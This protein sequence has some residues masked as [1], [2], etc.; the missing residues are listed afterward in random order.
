MDS[1]WLTLL[2]EA[3]PSAEGKLAEVVACLRQ[4]I[5]QLQQ[6]EREEPEPPIDGATLQ[7]WFLDLCVEHDPA[8]GRRVERSHRRRQDLADS[9]NCVVAK[10]IQAGLLPAGFRVYN[11]PR[12]KRPVLPDVEALLDYPASAFFRL[13]R[14]FVEQVLSHGR[15]GCHEEAAWDVYFGAVFALIALGG[16]CW[17]GAFT[18]IVQ[19]RA[20]HLAH[21][22]QGVLILPQQRGN[23][24]TTVVVQRNSDGQRRKGR[25][26]VRVGVGD[27]AVTVDTPSWVRVHLAPFVATCVAAAA[28]YRARPATPSRRR[29]VR[30]LH[31]GAD[32]LPDRRGESG[33]RPHH[34]PV[35]RMRR[36]FNRWLEQLCRRAGQPVLTVQKLGRLARTHLWLSGVYPEPV[37]A[38]LLGRI[39]YNPVPLNRL[40]IFDGYRRLLNAP[41]WPEQMADR[42]APLSRAS[43]PDVRHDSA[44]LSAA[45]R[46]YAP[47]IEA[48][49]NAVRAFVRGGGTREAAVAGLHS[50]AAGQLGQLGVQASPNRDGLIAG[51]R[52]AYNA[53]IASLL[54]I[55]ERDER[56]LAQI[57]PFNLAAVAL[58]LA[59]WL[60]KPRSDPLTV[61][62]HR[63]DLATVLRLFPRAALT[64][65]DSAALEVLLALDHAA[66]TKQRIR[67]SLRQL[68]RFL[69]K[70]LGVSLPPLEVERWP[71]AGITCAV[72][73]PAIEE[74]EELLA[75]FAR[76]GS[77]EDRNAYLAVCLAFG[78]GLRASE[79]A[80]LRIQD[81]VMAGGAFV[82][83][84]Q[85][86]FDKSR[87]VSL[88]GVSPTLLE[89]LDRIRR[90]R[91]HESGKDPLA[92][93]CVGPGGE[94][95]PADALSRHVTMG[96]K[97][98]GLGGDPEEGIPVTFHRLRH[99]AVCQ[100]LVRG[101]TPP[102]VARWVGHAAPGVTTQVYAHHWD[103]AQRERL[104]QYDDPRL[105]ARPYLTPATVAVLLDLSPQAVK[106]AVERSADVQRLAVSAAEGTV[107]GL[108]RGG[109]SET[110]V[111]ALEDVFR[112]MVAE[113]SESGA[114]L[115]G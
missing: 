11:Y 84:R 41:P 65:L 36:Q 62:A 79:V 104:R 92:P 27:E 91:W 105:P 93:L 20:C 67:G 95:I 5:M 21:L 106:A 89:N 3:F 85:S 53:K 113:L 29:S 17:E 112:L 1:A 22:D 72:H 56:H 115:A 14:Y 19:L 59:D 74:V 71:R 114:I 58:Y 23:R 44:P 81:V 50:F 100:Q 66:A 55:E 40:E 108:R 30:K 68:H 12:Q 87:R 88:E 64:E 26:L 7:A 18:A 110:R 47:G 28:V 103:W 13:C 83:V 24:S 86:K 80:A 8:T 9:F 25:C 107:W 76:R 57:R 42:P 39:P 16:V 49:Q 48:I 52:R 46:A 60:G 2:D 97:R 33:L 43:P 78:A 77:P 63:S 45:T 98:L 94:A 99:G 101:M 70:A 109:G 73:L 61:A 111:I 37:L 4:R 38:A 82:E 69:G 32:L 10:A 102:Q 6:H 90:Q 31:P 35:E 34:L 54:T 15:A 75:F 51:L 96:M